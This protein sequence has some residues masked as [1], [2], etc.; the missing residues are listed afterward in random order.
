LLVRVSYTFTPCK[1]IYKKRYV[2]EIAREFYWNMILLRDRQ[3][4]PTWKLYGNNHS[5]ARMNS[6][7]RGKKEDVM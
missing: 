3:L 4:V 7:S 5:L 1:T 2:Y 6:V